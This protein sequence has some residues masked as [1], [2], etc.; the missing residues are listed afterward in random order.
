MSDLTLEAKLDAIDD[1]CKAH[2]APLGLRVRCLNRV[3]NAHGQETVDVNH[4][5]L[6]HE[7]TEAISEALLFVTAADRLGTITHERAVLIVEYL[8]NAYDVLSA[9]GRS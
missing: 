2:N 6:Q 9:T 1:I 7:T 3:Q 4:R 5:G 8:S